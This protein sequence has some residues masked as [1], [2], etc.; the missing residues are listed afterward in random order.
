M[1][2]SHRS[3]NALKNS[4]KSSFL[5]FFLLNIVLYNYKYERDYNIDTANHAEHNP[6]DRPI[7]RWNRDDVLIAIE[8]VGGRATES[9]VSVRRTLGAVLRAGHVTSLRAGIERRPLSPAAGKSSSP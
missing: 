9:T 2:G 6:H 4:K 5:V 1:C 7:A 8:T 3:G